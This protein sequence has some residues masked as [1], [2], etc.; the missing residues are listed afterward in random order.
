MPRG[1]SVNTKL[2]AIGDQELP[3]LEAHRLG[4]RQ[5]DRNAARGGDEGER[6]AGVAAGRLDDFLAWP[7]DAALLGVPDQRRADAALDRIGR[8]AALDLGEH[9]RRRTVG[10][11]VEA[12]QRRMADGEGII[13]KP[14]WHQRAPKKNSTSISL[15]DY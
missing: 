1:P 15:L 2:R 14:A 7:Q 5:R 4:H 11:A 12:D 3:P 6:N 9:R 10:C 13:G 8:I